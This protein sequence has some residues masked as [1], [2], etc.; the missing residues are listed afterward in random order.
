MTLQNHLALAETSLPPAAEWSHILPGWCFVRLN[1]G[2]GYWLHK[3]STRELSVGDI[4]IVP[5]RNCGTFRSSEL[6][7][8]RLSYFCFCPDLLGGLLSPGERQFF[9]NLA[10]KSDSPPQFRSATEGPA[11]LFDELLSAPV[12]SALSQRTQMLRIVAEIF[13]HDA[14]SFQIPMRGHTIQERFLQLIRQMPEA[15]MITH[16]PE[17]L[18]KFCHCS[19]RHFSRLF[20]K[21]FGTPLRSRQTELRLQKARQ[22]L[23]DTDSKIINVALESGYRHLGL[24]N[25]T[26]KKYLGMTPSQ[27]RRHSLQKTRPKKITRAAILSLLAVFFLT[28][29]ASAQT[30]APPAAASTNA[31]PAFPVKGY[32]LEGNTVLPQDA[33]DKIF[34]EHTGPAVTFETIKQALAE[35]QLAY[36]GRGYVTVQVSLPQQQLTN[37]VVRVLVTEGRLAEINVVNNHYFSSNNIMAALPAL[38]TNILLNSL[39]FQQELDAANASRDRQIYPEILPGPEPGTTALLLKIK[40]RLPLHGHFELNNQSTPG[41][42]DLRMNFAAQYNNLWQL[43]HQLGAQYS[44]TPEE[45]KEADK[46]PWHFFDQPLIASY[47]AFYRLPVGKPGAGTRDV[48]L[49]TFGYDEATRRFRPPPPSANAEVLIYASRSDSDSGVQIQSETLTPAV[50]PPAGGLQ[51]S[52]RVVNQTLSLNEDLGMRILRPLPAFAGFQSSLAFGLDYKSYRATSLQTR[53]FQATIFIPEIG[54]TGPPFVEFPSPPT[55]SGRK[56]SSSVNYLPLALNWDGS[57]ADKLGS[58]TLSIN[59]TFHFA[60]VISGQNDF[61]TVAGTPR[62]SGTF[63]VLNGSVTREQ[64]I[65][66]EWSATLR[67][68]GQWATEPLINNEQFALGGLGGPRAYREGEEYGDCG[69]K[70][71][72]EPHTPLVDIGLVDGTESTRIR[73]SIFA[74]YGERYLLAPGTRP[75]SLAMAGAG[76]GITASIGQRV[77]MR[78]AFAWALLS[79]AAVSQGSSRVYFAVAA[80]F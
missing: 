14:G 55:T 20:R 75:G 22:L 41:T 3:N 80:Q 49:A 12:P 37:G 7:Q 43:D 51:V 15:E 13:S 18:A 39:V 50:L 25:A 5:P 70:I 17:D 46:L 34:S 67:A 9:E 31:V 73:G 62:A 72:V 30:P 24:F 36:R 38:R 48:P 26:F 27:W 54:A 8:A 66:D 4:V 53:I 52:D 74:D 57:R 58:T 28:R 64:K 11:K 65:Y 56:V 35:L 47:S 42:P 60:D 29:P 69:W 21:Y 76:F 79:T 19:V 16:S 68:S 71:S 33:L 44:F 10:A 77:D 63:Y 1:S 32:D 59:N 6:A 2:Y 23:S 45:F 40:D 61:A 78:L